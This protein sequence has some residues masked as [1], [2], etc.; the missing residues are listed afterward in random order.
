MAT[1]NSTQ[2]VVAVPSSD[3]ES[4]ASKKKTSKRK[5]EKPQSR[6]RPPIVDTEII[7]ISS[8]EE[9]PA[10]KPKATVVHATVVPPLEPSAIAELRREISRYRGVRAPFTF[11]QCER[12]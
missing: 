5:N 4:T 6:L 12:D 11:S 8:D 7:E 9:S 3:A 1:Q 10:P 2:I